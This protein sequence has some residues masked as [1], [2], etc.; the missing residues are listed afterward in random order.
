MT[1]WFDLA[2]FVAVVGAIA[3]FGQSRATTADRYMVAGRSIGLWALVATL[4]M[5]EF[6]TSTLLAFS[7][8]G[9]VAGPMA[10]ALPLV[11][12][13]GLGFYTLSVA[14]A[15]KRFDRLS[16]AELFATRY[17]PALGRLASALLLLAMLGFSA[18]YV[19]SLTLLFAP[20]AGGVNLWAVSALLTGVVLLMVVGG[21]L[22]S[23]V[24]A[25]Q[26]SF[27]ITLLLLPVLG[28]IG[29]WRASSGGGL[30]TAFPADQLTIDLVAQWRHPALSLRFV[31][32]L[33]V[34]TCMTYIAAPW[35]GQKIFAAR[36][37]RTAFLAVGLSA[38]LV[39]VL[40]GSMVFAASALRVELP[41]LADAQ[42]AVPEIMRRW[43][44][45]G[46]RGA[47]FGVLFAAA[48][49][50]LAGVWS[51]MAT[52]VAADL[53][54][55]GRSVRAQRALMLGFAILSWLGANLL[56]DD[57]LNRLILANIPVAALAFALLA[58]FHWRRATTAGAWVSVVV[59]VVW[60]I[61]CFVRLGDAGMYTWDWGVYGVPLIFLSGIVTSLLT[62]RPRA[63][64]VEAAAPLSS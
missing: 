14:R 18:T 53:A 30:A 2:G 64:P 34:L 58:G 6:N 4:V 23:I 10:L 50:T 31:T 7:A 60:G 1:I 24:R 37:E 20:F 36:D 21:G 11:F 15:W 26:V 59:G 63:L 43:L 52:M 19:K 35:Y 54:A 48:L 44:P 22:V 40:Y 57:I 12:L 5:T 17:S 49:T 38:V 27:G 25:D 33:V 16:V 8:A 32:S 47:G 13:I 28:L 29:W 41:A 9:Y 42:T 3:W 55:E 46:V 51:A 39:F 62:A 56:V 61:W 45:A